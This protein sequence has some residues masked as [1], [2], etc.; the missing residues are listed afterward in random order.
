[1]DFKLEG[2]SKDQQKG[3]TTFSCIWLLDTDMLM[4]ACPEK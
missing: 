3:R 2:S 1:M 4:E